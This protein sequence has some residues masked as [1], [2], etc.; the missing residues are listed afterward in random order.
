M[1]RHVAALAIAAAGAVPPPDPG[2]E[3][4]WG[5]R[6]PSASPATAAATAAKLKTLSA[7]LLSNGAVGALSSLVSAREGGTG[8]AH[9]AIRALFRLAQLAGGEASPQPLPPDQLDCDAVLRHVMGGEEDAHPPPDDVLSSALRLLAFPS[10]GGLGSMLRVD[11]VCRRLGACLDAAGTR[12]AAV[13]LLA[14]ADACFAPAGDAASTTAALNDPAPV[15]ALCGALLSVVTTAPAPEALGAAAALAAL[16]SRF[17]APTWLTS[18]LMDSAA[19]P[20][21]LVKLCAAPLPPSAA[22]VRRHALAATLMRSLALLSASF[23]SSAATSVAGLSRSGLTEALAAALSQLIPRDEALLEALHTPFRDDADGADALTCVWLHFHLSFPANAQ[24][25]RRAL[26]SSTSHAASLAARISDVASACV[27]SDSPRMSRGD[28]ACLRLARRAAMVP[29]AVDPLFSSLSPL[30][31]LCATGCTLALAA[32]A[33]LL[34][35]SCV[36]PH[37]GAAGEEAVTHRLAACVSL[38]MAGVLTSQLGM[39]GAAGQHAAEGLLGYKRLGGRVPVGAAG[40]LIALL[41][42]AS[43]DGAWLDATSVETLP[44]GPRGASAALTLL[45]VWLCDG[46]TSPFLNKGVPPGGKAWDA[47][48]EDAVRSLRASFWS[49]DSRGLR[50]A[51]R[52]IRWASQTNHAW[53]SLDADDESADDVANESAIVSSANCP[54]SF[55]ALRLCSCAPPSGLLAI[56]KAGGAG[57]VLALLCAQEDDSEGCLNFNRVHKVCDWQNQASH[58]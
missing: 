23:A 14:S 4:F 3:A 35:A 49:P 24:I 19:L 29:S 39:S 16:H 37:P 1:A 53:S 2:A 42:C 32:T 52:I 31:S 5:G 10:R 43:G 48:E 44:C 28:G 20:P 11:G 8:P 7:S 58:C 56:G 51:L 18:Q 13:D 17:A 6:P 57:D 26:C 22:G 27:G 55:G 9:A 41:G 36:P 40:P 21:S 34:S 30:A 45:S 33:T 25:H 15:A 54:P 46:A 47:D 12:A 50:A 38:G